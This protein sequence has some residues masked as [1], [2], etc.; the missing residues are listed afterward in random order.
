MRKLYLLIL[1]L[2][3]LVACMQLPTQSQP[4][5]APSTNQP[6]T[7]ARTPSLASLIQ[8]MNQTYG[9]VVPK[10]WGVHVRGV[11]TRL[12]TNDKV[13]ALTFDACGGKNGSGYDAKLINYLVQQKIPATLFINARWIT[14]NPVTFRQ[15]AHN[16][17]FEIENHGYK[18]SPLSVTPRVV[19]GIPST[20]NISDVVTEVWLN[21][22]KIAHLTGHHPRFFRSG[23][24]YYD[25]V[26]VKI[27][28]QLGERAVGFDVLGDA[29][30]TYNT[31]QV[32][33]ALLS[34]KPGSII[35]MHFN[36]P[37]KDTAEGVM[38]AIPLLRAEGFS[39]VKLDQ[40]L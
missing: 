26:S 35:I 22:Q 5:S 37:E 29:G 40:Y 2:F 8:Q 24:D 34:A 7:P 27:V 38:A 36:H 28:D 25:D 15:L 30:A 12:P 1:M 9:S 32:K 18:H 10:Q 11:I 23:T 3:S 31:Q 4:S 14:A 20:Q 19:Y 6:I 21:D 13:I 33:K 17:L 39:F 16:P